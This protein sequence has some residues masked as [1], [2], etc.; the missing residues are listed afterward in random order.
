MS[1]RGKE[2]RT[3]GKASGLTDSNPNNFF[4]FWSFHCAGEHSRGRVSLC[5]N[6]YIQ[7]MAALW[8]IILYIHSYKN[9]HFIEPSCKLF[10]K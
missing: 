8:Y 5:T 4:S 3:E 10:W 9:S 2:D 7:C 6:L 1:V